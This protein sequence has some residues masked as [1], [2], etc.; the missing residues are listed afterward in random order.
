MS[1]KDAKV[2]ANVSGGTAQGIIGASEVHVE[3][4]VI[5]NYAQPSPVPE[6]TARAQPGALPN[7]PYKG[8][9]HFGPDDKDLFFGRGST[10]DKLVKAVD[11]RS[12]N[13]VLG[14]SGCGKSSLLLA[15]VAPRL[16]ATGQWVFTYF[17]V[18]DSVEN[19]PFLALAQA[20]LPL[21]QPDLDETD[22]LLQRR[23]LGVALREGEI[24][25]T[26]VFDAIR[27]NW[28][29]RRV[30]LIADQFEELYTSNI[31]AEIQA[32]FMDFLIEAAR[33]SAASTPPAFSLAVTLRAD[34]LGLASLHR[35]FA[36]A[37]DESVH[38]LGPM[39]PDELRQAIVE[40]A[41]RCGV[42]FEEG[43]VETILADVGREPGNLPLLEFALTQMW[44]RQEDRRLT[45]SSYDGVGRVTGAL[46]KHA[47]K[48][49]GELDADG[50]LQARRIFTQLVK[51]GAGTEDT[52]RVAQRDELETIWPLVQ[53]LAG[54]ENRLVVT[55]AT[56][57]EGETAEVVHEALIK[58]WG[59]LRTWVAEDRTFLSWLDAFRGV[60]KTWIDHDRGE[61]DLLRGAA[62]GQA[63]EWI[64]KQGDGLNANE[65]AFIDASIEYRDRLAKEEQVRR[66]RELR[67][68]Q[69]LARRR[70]IIANGSVFAAI[71]LAVM[72]W[73]LLE[74]LKDAD[75]SLDNALITQSR[76]LADL[77]RQATR[78]GDAVTGML[79]A[80]EALPDESISRQRPYVLEAE[81]SIYEALK[82][83]R[84][85][86]VLSGHEGPIDSVRFTPDRKRLVTA[87]RDG[88][89]R[90]WDGKTG[91]EITVL[92][93]H[94][95]YSVWSAEF[96]SDGVNL[97]TATGDF[98]ARLW[99]AETGTEI[100]VLAGHTDEVRSAVFSPDG[101]RVVTASDDRTA[102]LWDVE[103]G[104]EIAVFA[105]H[106]AEVE[107][108][109][110]S[111]DGRRLL[112]VS[113]GGTARLW[114]IKSGAEIAV[115]AGHKGRIYAR[116][117]SPDGRRLLTASSD[118]TARLWN[119]KT[120]TVIAVLDGHVY[121]NKSVRFS[122]DGAHLVTAS[123]TTARLWDVET[124]TE[125]AVFAGHEG[126]I[127][128]AA[129][130]PDGRRV[131]TASNDRTARLWDVESG[132]EIA[133]FAGHE[134]EVESAA[135]IFDG[136]R[137]V[138]ASSGT[139]RLWDA[140]TGAVIANFVDH[141]DVVWTEGDAG[142]PIQKVM[143]T[144]FSLSPD[145]RQVVVAFSD[146]TMRL[147]DAE[148]G[149]EIVKLAGHEGLIWHASFTP[150]GERLV[151]V[152]D[153][154][155]VRLWDLKSNG[156][157][158][159]LSGHGD[160]VQSA[161]FSPDGRRL[162][163]ASSDHTA[164]LWDV[165]SGAEIAVF[166]GHEAEVESAAFSPDGARVVTASS[167]HTARLWDAQTGAE[168]AILAGHEGGVRSAV[169][170]PD[171]D[172]RRLVTASSDHTARLWDAES[173]TE[174]AVLEG[175]EDVAWR[176]G[177]FVGPNAMVNSAAFSP[178]GRR[179]V[180][181]SSDHTARLWT[182][183]AAPKS[184]CLRVMR[185]GSSL[186][187]SVLTVA[188]S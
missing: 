31:D 138:T 139:V 132:A 77:S 25:F 151:T 68:A 142:S 52:R 5:N 83:R 16:D 171:P 150:D 29:Q 59:T 72:G 56:A 173:G 26:D 182:P 154:L 67:D 33:V 42:T 145:D 63:E 166:A 13:A 23:K 91:I 121:S 17:R 113:S 37:I 104:A 48:V 167:D 40:P 100:A 153:D 133:V 58:H 46:T 123:R 180:T 7:N 12:F 6:E 105:G 174:I 129:F 179:L 108:A 79:L 185:T 8:L 55:N 10:I 186:P 168:I 14:P 4:L 20:L 115:H 124:G 110:F 47:D 49:F 159:V 98:V 140:Q 176:E 50:R 117:F 57:D 125:I 120:G 177:D 131:V 2:R 152:S 30:L 54:P 28:S 76:F 22:R 116:T 51:P 130:S 89:T 18:S 158:A 165:E 101:R 122:P 126:G 80:V 96:S 41:D 44:D 3:R 137:V 160:W 11:E 146:G 170:S 163:S 162:V 64:A 32:R 106:E 19:D 175:H 88:T 82:Q 169:F 15:G 118:G 184:P 90:L 75:Q 71:V 27:R 78:K 109:A 134:A 149:A 36:D 127:N 73:F 9:S 92:G 102:R 65:K 24:P 147:W 21:Y 74:V 99:E 114:D 66:E 93:A 161:A 84:E 148:T 135:F 87:S 86:V 69:I 136:R 181:A 45:L 94:V 107:S 62:L 70:K 53:R 183:R 187:L 61:E 128:S 155:T 111:P 119:V 60:L 144:T 141:E 156:G 157:I 112:T 97:V 38:I 81:K 178:D 143:V 43:L 85:L 188:A 34:F 164:R 95:G 1:R 35:S 39:T 172:G 103:S